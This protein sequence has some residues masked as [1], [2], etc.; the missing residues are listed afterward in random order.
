M[1]VL[2]RNGVHMLIQPHLWSHVSIKSPALPFW[3]QKHQLCSSLSVCALLSPYFHHTPNRFLAA[4]TSF[5]VHH[6]K[7]SLNKL[8]LILYSVILCLHLLLWPCYKPCP[9]TS[10]GSCPRCIQF[11]FLPLAHKTQT[12]G[13]CFSHSFYVPLKL[14]LNWSLIKTAKHVLWKRSLNDSTTL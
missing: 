2:T 1:W 13:Q 6:P 9:W 10:T 11:K 4:T 3:P 7:S 12:W 14:S 5:T 8:Q